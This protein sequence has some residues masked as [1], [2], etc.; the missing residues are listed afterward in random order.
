MASFVFNRAKQFIVDRS[1]GT[2][3]L[4]GDTI[5]VAL[6]T[7][8]ASPD[9]DNDYMSSFT[10]TE[11]SCTGYTAGYGGAGRV[12]VAATKAWSEVDA[13]NLAMFD[14]TSD[15]T[16]TTCGA[17]YA[18]AAV[19]YVILLKE[20]TNDA[21]SPVIACFQLATTVMPNGGNLVLAWNA[22]GL[23]NLTD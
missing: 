17:A 8:A 12:T 5:K 1:T 16:W 9:P 3:D 13:S 11:L 19:Q 22:S 18:G 21:A 6:L 7:T 10:A 14:A 20:V 2:L 15:I 23:I 4:E